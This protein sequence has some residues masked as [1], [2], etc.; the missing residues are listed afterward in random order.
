MEQRVK[1]KMYNY[2][3]IPPQGV[4]EDIAAQLDREQKAVVIPMNKKTNRVLY[5]SLAAAASLA[6]IV[7]AVIFWPSKP[8]TTLSAMDIKK[9]N[10]ELIALNKQDEPIE[11][12]TKI[13]VPLKERPAEKEDFAVKK[14]DKVPAK[15]EIDQQVKPDQT[16]T[17]TDEVDETKDS[18]KPAYITITGPEG[19]VVKVSSKVTSLME[20]SEDP[21]KP[22]WNKK[23]KE[24]KTQMQ[25]NTLAPTPG[26]F[27][28]I[29][30][31]TKSL[32][33]K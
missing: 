29:I 19:Q 24:W 2:E 7:L 20:S 13:T 15:K 11:P 30:E 6:V 16:S 33:D 31:L 28:D 22:V 32:K 4:W 5:Y 8:G 12:S 14:S 25:S 17:T 18:D 3:E 23:V 1:E 21:A 9:T 10:V 27:M 26:N